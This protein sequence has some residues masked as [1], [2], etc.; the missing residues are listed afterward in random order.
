MPCVELNLSE[1]LFYSPISKLESWYVVILELLCRKMGF[2][3]NPYL[4]LMLCKYCGLI[5]A[6]EYRQKRETV[7][8]LMTR[9]KNSGFGNISITDV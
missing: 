5:M 7:V 2:N 8:L 9:A 6:A 1:H 4:V 3:I